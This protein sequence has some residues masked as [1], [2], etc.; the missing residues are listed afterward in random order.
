MGVELVKSYAPHQATLHGFPHR[1]VG[2][3]VV[4]KVDDVQA[5][6]AGDHM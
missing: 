6:A 2:S 4:Q 1:L 5:V 3:R